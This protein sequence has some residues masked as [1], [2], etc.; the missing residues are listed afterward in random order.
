LLNFIISD[1]GQYS[2]DRIA[3]EL[4]VE[5][6]GNLIPVQAIISVPVQNGPGAQTASCTMG[7]VFF[8]GFNSGRGVTMTITLLVLLSRTTRAITVYTL[9]SVMQ[10]EKLSACTRVQITS[11]FLLRAN[12][13]IIRHRPQRA[14]EPQ[15]CNL[16]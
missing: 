6:S 4:R 12:T 9:W 1:V 3:S 8:L 10:A 7:T 15:R 13:V 2:S 14:A 5:R 11:L 16:V